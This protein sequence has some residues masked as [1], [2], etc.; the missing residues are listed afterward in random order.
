VFEICEIVLKTLFSLQARQNLKIH[1]KK[2]YPPK[3]YLGGFV[4][5][6]WQQSLEG[7]LY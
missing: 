5:S 6:G 2:N 1:S 3:T 4:G 7:T